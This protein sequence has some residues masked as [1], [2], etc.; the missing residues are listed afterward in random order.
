MNHLGVEFEEKKM[1][2]MV[3]HLQVR[4]L[5]LDR[6]RELQMQDDQ[7]KKIRQQVVYKVST[8]FSIFD[9]GT[10]MFGNRFCIPNELELKN[11]I[12]GEAH[13]SLLTKSAHFLLVKVTYSLD[14]Y[15]KLYVDE[16]TDGQSE[17]TIQILEDMLR[18]CMLDFKGSWN[19]YI[20]LME[21]AY[22]NSYQS[23]IGMAPFKVLYDRKCRTPVCW[24]EVGERQLL[25]P[26]MI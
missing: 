10:V 7:L 1:G 26:E 20:A 11:D 16:I 19:D 24:T 13:Q 3:A 22:N 5:L 2:V 15:A 18:A 25:G 12:L 14:K 23:S 17:R 21:F 4:P 9:D 8:D 6:I